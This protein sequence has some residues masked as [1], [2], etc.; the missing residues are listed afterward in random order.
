M[1]KKAHHSFTIDELKAAYA[2][3]YEDEQVAAEDHY[4]EYL[5][6]TFNPEERDWTDIEH[7]KSN[8]RDM[9]AEAH[10]SYIEPIPVLQSAGIDNAMLKFIG[11]EPEEGL[12][13]KKVE[14]K[15]DWFK[16]A[17]KTEKKGGFFRTSDIMEFLKG[18]PSEDFTPRLLDQFTDLFSIYTLVRHC[19]KIIPAE[20][21]TR[22]FV[23]RAA[24]EGVSLLRNLQAHITRDIAEELIEKHTAKCLVYIPAAVKD[25]AFMLECL[26]KDPRAI[27][28]I[29]KA[30]RTTE[31][32]EKAI[33]EG[34]ERTKD[35]ISLRCEYGNENTME[36]FLELIP[37]GPNALS[38][39]T[40]RQLVTQYTHTLKIFSEQGA[41]EPDSDGNYS[42]SAWA[43]FYA[44]VNAARP[45]SRGC[46]VTQYV[47]I[48]MI[49]QLCDKV[50]PKER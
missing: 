8:L 10:E 33:L 19:N 29:P 7:A 34:L 14:K 46:Q 40:K 27:S 37:D 24:E 50:M 25:D 9:I 17:V 12:E 20:S 21:I 41:F 6:A 30:K 36:R 11:L 38:V 13:P 15:V 5:T 44:G 43:M 42:E 45:E 23:L 22:D 31:M 48:G 28:G 32:C 26:E 3:L 49:Q 2:Y 16:L 35:N 39:E 47:P 1:A 4:M 18:I